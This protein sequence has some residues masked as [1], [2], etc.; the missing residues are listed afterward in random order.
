MVGDPWSFSVQVAEFSSQASLPACL[1]SCYD[2]N[3]STYGYIQ[4]IMKSK[5]RSKSA[6]DLVFV[7]MN[8]RLLSRTS[9]YCL[10]D[11]ESRLWDV[12]GDDFLG[13]VLQSANFS[14]DEP[15][16]ELEMLEEDYRGVRENQMAIEKMAI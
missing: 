12:G 14:F 5:Q 8:L 11:P 6:E 16:F 13:C 1:P 9:E 2:R 3:W 7:H 15:E 4:K 10:T